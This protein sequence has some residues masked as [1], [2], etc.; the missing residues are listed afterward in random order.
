MVMLTGVKA[1]VLQMDQNA[2]C[3]MY[4]GTL[5]DIQNENQRFSPVDPG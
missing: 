3:R 5:K 2:P 4:K 1:F